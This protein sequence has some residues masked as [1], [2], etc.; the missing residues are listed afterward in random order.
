[1]NCKTI[2]H[3]SQWYCL[4]VLSQICLPK[5]KTNCSAV[6]LYDLL[7]DSFVKTTVLSSKAILHLFSLIVAKRNNKVAVEPYQ[8]CCAAFSSFLHIQL[9]LCSLTPRTY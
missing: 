4:D 3:F 6:L 2:I 7:S 5:K 8:R 9:C 1:M